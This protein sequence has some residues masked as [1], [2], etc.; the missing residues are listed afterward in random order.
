MKVS[1][2]QGYE[3]LDNPKLRGVKHA[4]SQLGSANSET[5][6]TKSQ[7]ETSHLHTTACLPLLQLFLSLPSDHRQV[8]FEH[9]VEHLYACKYLLMNSE[10]LDVSWLIIK[11]IPVHLPK[12]HDKDRTPQ[13]S[14]TKSESFMWRNIWSLPPV[15]T[16]IHRLLLGRKYE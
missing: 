4:S 1:R 11:F 14:I 10:H 15:L 6:L 8:N 16:E 3:S 12:L 13:E 9:R 7:R 5:R 2:P